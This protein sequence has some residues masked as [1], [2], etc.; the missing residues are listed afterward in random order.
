MQPVAREHTFPALLAHQR[1]E[2]DPRG[3]G[4]LGFLLRDLVELLDDAGDDRGIA[5]AGCGRR[6]RP[7]GLRQPDHTRLGRVPSN[8]AM[9]ARELRAVVIRARSADDVIRTDEDRDEG[10]PEGAHLGELLA[11]EVVGGVAIHRGVR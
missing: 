3:T 6:E 2:I 9:D 1:K 10:R 4:K 8:R 7:V 5:E 11:D